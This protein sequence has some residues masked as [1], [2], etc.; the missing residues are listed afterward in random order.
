MSFKVIRGVAL[1][2]LLVSVAALDNGVARLPILGYN[3]WNAYQCN[4]DQDLVL[5]TAK[6]MKSLGLLDVGYHYVNIDDCYAEKN[7]TASGD[8]IPG[9]WDPIIPMSIL[10]RE[11][12]DKIRFPNIT[13]MTNQIHDLGFKTGIFCNAIIDILAS[14]SGWFTC[15]GYPGSFQNEL[16]DATTFQNW[17]FDYL[18]YD[19]CAIPYDDIIREGIVGKYQR[20]ADALETLAKTSGKPPF[21]F[22]LCEWGWSQVWLWGKNLGHSWRVTGDIAPQWDSLAFIINFNSFITQATDFSGHNDMDMLQLGNGGLT[23]E[24]AKSHFTAWAL[25]KSPLLIGTN[26]S[27]ITPDILGILK[28][29]EILAINQDPVVGQSISP[30]RWGINPDW[31]SNSTFPAQYWSGPSQNGTVIMLLN[32]LNEP[33]TMF[34]NLTESPFIRA[35]RQYSV[36]DLWAH[37]NNGT[38][39]RNFTAHDVP[40]HGVVALLLKDAGNEPSGI[41]PACSVWFQCTDK[42][43]THVGRVV[44]SG[45]MAPR[46]R[47]KKRQLSADPPSKNTAQLPQ[48][49][50]DAIIDEFDPSLQDDYNWRVFP[51][52]KA[53]R[54][55]AVVASAFTRPS[56]MKLFSA[57]DLRPLDLYS[58]SPD[59]RSRLFAKL[60]SS[61]PH[62][63]QY[64][65]NLVLAYRCGRSTSLGDILSSLPK[66]AT[67]SLH[68][69][70]DRFRWFAQSEP[71]PTYHRESFLAA[72]SLSSLRRLALRNHVFSD[73]LELQSLLSNSIGLEEL[74][75]RSI[76]FTDTLVSDPYTIRPEPLRVVIRSLE[77]LDMSVDHID[78][79]LNCFTV[80]DIRHLR[81]FC[82]DRYYKAL[83]AENARSI[84]KL[85]LII[86]DGRATFYPDRIPLPVGL[87]SLSLIHYSPDS[88]PVMMHRLGNLAAV[89]S[90]TQLSFT[91]GNYSRDPHASTWLQTDSLLSEIGSGLAEIHINFTDLSGNYRHEKAEFIST[92]RQSIPTMNTKAMLDISFMSEKFRA[93]QMRH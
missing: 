87:N 64:V 63:G 59:E 40:P 60:L 26:L 69:W 80:V 8:I 25:M 17:G 38:A 5:T 58:Q 46:A 18:K 50:I 34:F 85:T 10:K 61:S 3:T 2:S 62:I 14:D 1:A 32:T 88:L 7:R 43:G 20:M 4:I 78:A 82:C 73:A 39:V 41:F 75:L 45:I 81:S 90:L 57:V 49:L 52:R 48:E 12:P 54:S 30:F 55:C 15:A 11:I 16:R 79:V 42:N 91:M 66:L 72:F 77:L 28:N 21:V 27:A 65:K 37:T 22:S 89:N 35:G 44:D 71:F 36:R 9:W 31:T 68:P 74:V 51:D 84:E 53:L 29:T 56:Q 92:V 19:N 47:T 6:L 86:K 76:E 70:S 13:S 33:S 23:F 93:T 24:E 83:F 67:L